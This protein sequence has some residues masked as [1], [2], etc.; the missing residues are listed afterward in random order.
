MTDFKKKHLDVA[1]S[2]KLE[3]SRSVNNII[4]G[5]KQE[6]EKGFRKRRAA[7]MKH[8]NR[9]ADSFGVVD[10]CLTLTSLNVIAPDLRR[11][12]SFRDRLVSE[13]T[14]LFCE[15]KTFTINGMFFLM[16]LSYVT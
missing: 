6:S 1:P 16:L 7:S 12:G 14:E 3:R 15:Y 2:S 4:L 10:I 8:R 11:C 13:D 5:L 9:V